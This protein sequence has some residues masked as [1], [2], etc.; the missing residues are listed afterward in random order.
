MDTVTIFSWIQLPRM[1]MLSPLVRSKSNLPNTCCRAALL[2]RTWKFGCGGQLM[3]RTG[4]PPTTTIGVELGVGAGGAGAGVLGA[5]GCQAWM[6][7]G[8]GSALMR[9]MTPS[10]PAYNVS[11]P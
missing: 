10:G 2:C 5:V 1:R 3:S 11:W 9:L 8:L 7:A 6:S 4:V